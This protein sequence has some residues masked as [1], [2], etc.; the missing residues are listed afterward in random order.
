MT[1]GKVTTSEHKDELLTFLKTNV[2]FEYNSAQSA[3]SQNANFS[4]K[5]RLLVILILCMKDVNELGMYIEMVEEAHKDQQLE[6]DAL[7]KIN[8]MYNKKMVSKS[9]C[10]TATFSNNEF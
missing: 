7:N 8:V 9:L 1:Q 6:R 2:P 3:A 4:D 5:L 10:H